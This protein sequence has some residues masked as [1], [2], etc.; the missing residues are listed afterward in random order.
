MK[1]AFLFASGLVVVLLAG[2][3][4]DSG[5]GLEIHDTKFVA[6]DSGGNRLTEAT[7]SWPCVLDI[8]TG[9]MWEA[10]TDAPGL[11]DWRNTY[12]W[13]DPGEAHG[14]LDY[15]GLPDGG[16]CQGSA[17]DTA[18]FVDSV[19]AVGL[20]G[21][22][23]WRVPTKNELATLSDLRKVSNPP[24]INVALFPYAQAAEYWTSNDYH[25]Q[26]NSAWVW[27]FEFGHDRVEWKESP[28]MVRVV[29]GEGQQIERVKD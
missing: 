18:S 25:F 16:E 8:Y 27:N 3:G 5:P 7:G 6:V 15:R 21:F 4:G 19:N 22:N 11:H 29:R 13:Y 1:S 23:D 12:S 24:T 26:W 14:E 2:C 17:C 10:K 28:R 9:L 20:C